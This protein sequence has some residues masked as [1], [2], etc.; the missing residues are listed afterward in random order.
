MLTKD[1]F[2]CVDQDFVDTYYLVF[3]IYSEVHYYT[4]GMMKKLEPMVS[5]VVK[6]FPMEKL[7]HECIDLESRICIELHRKNNFI[8]EIIPYYKKRFIDSDKVINTK[9][10]T[11]KNYYVIKLNFNDII[12][13][14]TIAGWIGG[15]DISSR[16]MFTDNRCVIV[17]STLFGI[18]HYISSGIATRIYF[19]NDVINYI[20]NFI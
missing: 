7:K 8:K 15:N 16:S 17:T 5:D 14:N 10:K 11:N 12:H 2:I 6:N 19:K 3:M 18:N 4:Y 1:Y 13:I 20:N 9:P